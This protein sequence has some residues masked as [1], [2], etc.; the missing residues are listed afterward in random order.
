MVER[1]VG[2]GWAGSVARGR[3]VSM[4]RRVPGILRL[5]VPVVDFVVGRT[6]IR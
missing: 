4:I 3:R 2:R 5:L 6:F 1:K